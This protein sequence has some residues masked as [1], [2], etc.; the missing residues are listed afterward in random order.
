M[1]LGFWATSRSMAKP[2]YL[3]VFENKSTVPSSS[4]SREE[5]SHMMKIFNASRVANKRKLHH[6]HIRTWNEVNEES[7]KQKL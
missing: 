2:S 3:T 5:R 4:C 7:I 1:D 6:W